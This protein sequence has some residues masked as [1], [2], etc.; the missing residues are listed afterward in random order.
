MNT[1]YFT[2]IHNHKSIKSEIGWLRRAE[3]RRVARAHER[4]TTT[5]SQTNARKFFSRLTVCANVIP[6]IVFRARDTEQVYYYGFVTTATII[7]D[8]NVLSGWITF[9]SLALFLPLSVFFCSFSGYYYLEKPNT[10]SDFGFTVIIFLA[11]VSVRSKIHH[12]SIHTLIQL[13]I[14]PNAHNGCA[15]DNNKKMWKREREWDTAH[16]GT[17]KVHVTKRTMHEKFK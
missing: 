7:I 14:K 13:K 12:S 4:D 8:G 17:Q 9:F 11:F 1:T 5:R 2:K 6:A 3:T 15:N 16:Q 10:C